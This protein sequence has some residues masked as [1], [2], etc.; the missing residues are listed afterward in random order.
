MKLNVSRAEFNK[1]IIAS[2][3]LST[4]DFE[5]FLAREF[6]CKPYTKYEVVVH[7]DSFPGERTSL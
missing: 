7:D 2:Q 5:R 6:G 1:L 4:P 3:E